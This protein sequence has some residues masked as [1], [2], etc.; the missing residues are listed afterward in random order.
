MKKEFIPSFSRK[1]DRAM[2]L[3]PEEIKL[4]FAE[5]GIDSCFFLGKMMQKEEVEISIE[6]FLTIYH[7]E[8]DRFIQGNKSLNFCCCALV[9]DRENFLFKEIGQQVI[10]KP[11]VPVI[12]I[13][14]AYFT[15][16]KNGG[17]IQEKAFGADNIFWGI[18]CSFFQLYMDEQ[19]QVH[20]ALTELASG[21]IFR[22]LFAWSRVHTKPVAFHYLD[23]KIATTLRI[24]KKIERIND[25]FY[26]KKEGLQVL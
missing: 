19:Q 15:L 13:S 11:K 22:N 23:K 9:A 20:Q 24:G 5:L 14:F 26:L 7:Q 8:Y 21:K 3:H 25:N 17:Q 12:Q 2:L 1:M 10:V 4:L 16:E 18:K 6:Q